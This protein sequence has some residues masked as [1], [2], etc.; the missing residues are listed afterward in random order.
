MI[1]I[2]WN[3]VLLYFMEDLVVLI[4]GIFIGYGLGIIKF[5]N[6]KPNEGETK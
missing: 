4:M 6:T 1:E 2:D 5:T 3:W